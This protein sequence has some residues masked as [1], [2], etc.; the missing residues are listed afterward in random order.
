[1]NL[2][3]KLDSV[4]NEKAGDHNFRAKVEVSVNADADKYF[5]TDHDKEI[6]IPYYI[7]VEYRTWG[8]HSLDVSIPG[9]IRIWI[10]LEDVEGNEQDGH[11]TVNLSDLP[12]EIVPGDGV[13]LKS[14]DLWIDENGK[15][16][17]EMSQIHIVKPS[18]SD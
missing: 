9:T 4:L 6:T 15:V 14:L 3:D 17:Y 13:W 7:N 8:I 5:V 12:R 10:R 11:V 2:D 16:D 1:M 18:S